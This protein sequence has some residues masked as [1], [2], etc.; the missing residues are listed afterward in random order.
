MYRVDGVGRLSKVGRVRGF[1]HFDYR[2]RY[3][4]LERVKLSGE[5][6]LFWLMNLICHRGCWGG[7]ASMRFVRFLMMLWVNRST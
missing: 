4:W 1:G 7:V 6:M 5:A 2:V 3:A